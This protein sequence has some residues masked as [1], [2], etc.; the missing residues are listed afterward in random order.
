MKLVLKVLLF[1]KNKIYVFFT[2]KLDADGPPAGGES[3]IPERCLCETLVIMTK[4]H[5]MMDDE[6]VCFNINNT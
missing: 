5:T 1:K 3:F 6:S 4:K 2:R